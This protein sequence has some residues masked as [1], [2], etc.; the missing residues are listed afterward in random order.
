MAVEEQVLVVKRSV[1]EQ[2]GAFQGLTFD[3]ERYLNAFFAQ[4]VQ[5]SQNSNSLPSFM[6]RSLAETDP[7]HKQLIPY[8]IMMHDGKVL[9]YVRGKRAGET[10]L[11]GR[12]SIGIG[13]HINPI[14]DISPIDHNNP[15]NDKN[16]HSKTDFRQVYFAAVRRE[17]EEEINI[18]GGIPS[19][20]GDSNRVVA[21]INDDSTEVGQVHLGIVHLWNLDSDA[22]E[23]REQMI[24]QMAFT[25]PTELQA[26][27]ES[28][29][30]WSQ[31]C[32]DHLDEM[33]TSIAP[34]R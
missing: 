1:F 22:V 30:T 32:L 20:M 12:R 7:T 23:K 25:T 2:V 16:P 13:G 27:R 9:S 6:L 18:A 11:V 28:L 14:D 26:D 34:A 17:V 33:C 15:V 3:P 29:E 4:N 31:L 24:T 21:L 5:S 19:S 8:V 10:R